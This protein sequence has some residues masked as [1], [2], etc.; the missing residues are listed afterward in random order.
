MCFVGP[1]DAWVFTGQEDMY[2]VSCVS[3]DIW[4]LMGP[5]GLCVS[6]VS[7]DTWVSWD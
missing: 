6:I 2:S 7:V 5:K 4:V 3:K 1:E